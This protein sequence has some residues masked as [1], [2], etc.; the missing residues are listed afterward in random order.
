VRC[1]GLPR[2]VPEA[3]ARVARGLPRPHRGR[4]RMGEARGRHRS[5]HPPLQPQS[6]GVGIHR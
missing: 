1:P 5:A 3:A 4:R 2:L 6:V